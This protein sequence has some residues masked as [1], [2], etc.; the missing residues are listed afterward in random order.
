MLR[1]ASATVVLCFLAPSAFAQFSYTGFGPNSWG[2]PDATLG[3]SDV[4][5]EDFEDTTLLPNLLIGVTSGAGSRAPSNTIPAVFNSSM[6]PNGS[7]FVNGTWD[8]AYGLISTR[9]N[10]S[11]NYFD[12]PQWG[13][14]TFQITGAT[15]V[16][17]F[18]VQQADADADVYVNGER[19]G[20]L[21]SLFGLPINGSR[22]GYCVIKA[23]GEALIS[24]VT[25]H[26]NNNGDGFMFDH[27][28][29]V[30]APGAA[31]LLSLGAL[32]AGRRRR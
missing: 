30:P 13:V 27:V 29:I 32:A 14:T 11:H 25:I 6:D 22:N 10:A 21:T 8:G 15:W 20:T 12:A 1:S 2:V 23:T 7:A 24:D 31:A 5:I 19:V 3:L 28:A 26:N 9:D 17:G 16:F 18:S 4:A